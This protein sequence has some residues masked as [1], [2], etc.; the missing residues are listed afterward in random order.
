MTT[1]CDA[2]G[3]RG[4]RAWLLVVAGGVVHPFTGV[5]IPG[6]VALQGPPAFEKAGK[7]S[8]S[9]YR[10]AFAEGARAVAGRDGWETGRFL[11]G[12][13]A[14]SGLAARPAAEPAT[15]AEVAQALGVSVEEARR[16]LCSWRPKAAER[17]DADA[18]ALAALG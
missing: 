12:L 11:E 6:V 13:Q 3:S 9:T 4:R 8:N 2:P 15:W 7:W 1:W 5:G 10:L 18:A 17:L 16:F 14:A